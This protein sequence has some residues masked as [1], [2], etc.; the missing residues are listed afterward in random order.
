[1]KTRSVLAALIVCLTI[2]AISQVPQNVQSAFG[3]MYPDAVL[4]KF[5][6]R[7]HEY[8]A[9]FMNEGRKCTTVFDERGDW[10]MTKISMK[11][12]DMPIVVKKGLEKSKY[13]GWFI[14]DITLVETPG[15]KIYTVGVDNN[16]T[17]T[18]LGGYHITYFTSSGKL[19]K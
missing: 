1:M 4:R 11:R 10:L 5:K 6:H 8:I 15:S 3:G 18:G 14:E 16:V 17:F 13:H 2:S 9:A 19:L 7:H 12:E